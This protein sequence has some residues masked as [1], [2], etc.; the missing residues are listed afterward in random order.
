MAYNETVGPGTILNFSH[1]LQDLDPSGG[2]KTN[3]YTFA[4]SVAA[5]SGESCGNDINDITVYED[6]N[7]NGIL[8]S[9]ET[10][11]IC[12][13]SGCSSSSSPSVTVD[14]ETSL[15]FIA[16]IA[17][18]DIDDQCE[19]DITVSDASANE[20]TADD[21]FEVVASASK[22]KLNE[23]MYDPTTGS[24]WLEISNLSS[25][26]EMDVSSWDISD[27]D[28]NA[29][30]ISA[31]LGAMPAADTCGDEARMIIVNGSGSDDTDWSDCLVTLYTGN[32]GGFAG[33]A[34]WLDNAADGLSLCSG[35]C[36]ATTIVDYVAYGA[37]P[38]TGDD[39]ATSAGI[40]PG[41]VY[42]ADVATGTSLS[43]FRKPTLDDGWDSD[44]YTDWYEAIAPSP[45]EENTPS[46]VINEVE[47]YSG[48]ATQVDWAE[49]H[50]IEDGVAGDYS[51]NIKDYMLTNTPT[52]T[53]G[54]SDSDT[55]LATEDVWV[56]NGDY[57]IIHFND[58]S[59]TDETYDYCL[60]NDC[61]DYI[62]LY[63]ADGSP[64][65]AGDE[66]ALTTAVSGGQFL[67][68][69]VWDIGSTTIL[70]N[71]ALNSVDVP[72]WDSTTTV[73]AS[74][75]STDGSTK[76]TMGRDSQSTD[77]NN[78]AD[79]AE[80]SGVDAVAD[81]KGRRNVG[82]IINEVMLDPLT[83]N[84]WVE[85]YCGSTIN[86]ATT[87]YQVAYDGGT[88]NITSGSCTASGSTGGYL[89]VDLGGSAELSTSADTLSLNDCGADADCSAT[90]DNSLVDFIAYGADAGTYD[91]SAVAA[92][93]WVD[94]DYISISGI[95]E[96]ETFGR[97][98]DQTDTNVSTDWALHGGKDA[99]GL[100]PGAQNIGS[101]LVINEVMYDPASGSDWIELY[102]PGDTAV[103]LDDYTIMDAAGNT[104]TIDTDTTF[105][106]LENIPA[107]EYLIIVFDDGGSSGSSDFYWSDGDA[108]ELHIDLES[109]TDDL[110]TTDSMAL[111]HSSTT[112]ETTI[113][114]YVAWGGIPDT[115]T[116]GT[117]GK[118]AVDAGI[119][120][121]GDYV[122]TSRGF[123]RR[124]HRPRQGF[125]RYR[126][127]RRLGRPRWHRR[128][129]RN[130][131]RP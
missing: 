32:D 107:G 7:G 68:G 18:A 52:S 28:G 33:G 123:H 87:P 35:T 75:F 124:I 20:K 104:Y 113:V 36:S 6:T 93:L 86:F 96:G 122:D 62:D 116:A 105:T 119:W 92:G 43:R 38:G 126:G 23:V 50:M 14:K 10:T 61:G 71:Y 47:I 54:T 64:T 41:G 88:Y 56:T 79:W 120:T 100:T 1:E 74:T 117:S 114:D 102:N 25:W 31:A 110:G 63:V 82:A 130:R 111:F 85:I 21:N 19:I 99:I 46:V 94:S 76:N 45:G 26:Y 78:A 51:V 40:W 81:T 109:G 72:M 80:T 125:D 17:A 42:S 55:A 83:G 13:G 67:D 95:I 66:L 16:Q 129:R 121:A 115:T 39:N 8:D 73:D 65:A 127:Q 22:V 89:Q 29:F 24:E 3:D 58:S 77:S 70:E 91:D 101:N 112:D 9:S 12:A 2:A 49:L 69:V 118:Y 59:S 15:F 53:A 48:D 98:K 97:D 108:A 60:T 57:V 90:G 27:N 128:H 131:R 34:D 30:T 37:N 4:I 103:S 11:T 84:Q 106:E 5:A 44:D